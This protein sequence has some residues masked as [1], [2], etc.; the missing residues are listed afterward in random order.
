MFNLKVDSRGFEKHNKAL[1][2]LIPKHWKT[3][4][5]KYGK[6]ITERASKVHK[7]KN[8]TGNLS[9]SNKWRVTANGGRLTVRNTMYYAKYVNSWEKYKKSPKGK[10]KGWLQN[11]INYYKR[12][13]ADELGKL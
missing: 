4:F 11:A 10:G 9:K 12:A 2:K 8:R 3:V 13:M 5:N 6:L 7:Y 1:K